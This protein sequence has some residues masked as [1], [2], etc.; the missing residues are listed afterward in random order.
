M[1]ACLGMK[2]PR[3]PGDERDGRQ[4]PEVGSHAPGASTFRPPEHVHPPVRMTDEDPV[5]RSEKEAS[6]HN[7][8]D[9]EQRALKIA[10]SPSVTRRLREHAVE[11]EIP[12]FG[13]KW[14]QA[15]AVQSQRGNQ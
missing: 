13:Y 12:V 1:K 7:T 2:A 9:S 14:S 5:R 8:G 6:V 11:D 4:H 15:G 10:R 3:G